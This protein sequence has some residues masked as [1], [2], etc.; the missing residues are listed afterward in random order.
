MQSHLLSRTPPPR[1]ATRREVSG[2]VVI[3]AG[4]ATAPVGA[5][6]EGDRR[7]HVEQHPSVCCEPPSSP[8][9]GDVVEAVVRAKLRGDP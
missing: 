1:K 3:G 8:M 4:G 5:L 7:V 9:F 2:Q 6:G